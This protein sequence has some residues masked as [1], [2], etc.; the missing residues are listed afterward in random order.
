MPGHKDW[1]PPRPR[2]RSHTRP[3]YPYF[4]SSFRVCLA[5]SA[6]PPQPG[7]RCGR[8]APLSPPSGRARVAA[9]AGR[10]AGGSGEARRRQAYGPAPRPPVPPPGPAGPP[11]P[12]RA[13]LRRSS[14]LCNVSSRSGSGGGDASGSGRGPA[15][16][17][18]AARHGPAG[19]HGPS[20]RPPSLPPGRG[21]RLCAPRRGARTRSQP[22]QRPRTKDRGRRAPGTGRGGRT[23]APRALHASA[24][25]AAGA[26]AR[27]GPVI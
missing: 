21:G 13:P 23:T 5:P 7:A 18:R 20:P 22:R 17:A 11:P 24:S 4:A 16:A 12:R 9:R 1:G 2:V 26:R 25:P 10:A 8:R 3:L 19:A 14:R 27:A 15:V 6:A